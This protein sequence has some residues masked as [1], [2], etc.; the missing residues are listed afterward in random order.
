MFR[1]GNKQKIQAVIVVLAAALIAY[2]NST[3]PEARYTGAPGDLG[4]CVNCHDTFER[5]NVGP[6]N[7]EIGG[8]PVVYEP[9]RDYTLTVTVQQ[10]NRTRYGFQLTAID[11]DGA[12]AGTFAPLNGDTQLNV[13]TGANGRQYIQHTSQGTNPTTSGRRIWQ[14]RWT[15]PATD[16]G[17]VRFFVAGNAANGDGTNQNDYIYTNSAF[18]ESETTLV[19]LTLDSDPSGQELEP[20]SKYI[21]DWSATN[22]S[23]VDSYELRYSTDD[24]ATFPITNLIFSTTDPDITE[25]EWAVPDVASTSVRLRLQGATKAGALVGPILSGKFSINGTGTPTPRITSARV[26]GKKLFVSGENFQQGA[27]VEMN[28]V[29]QKTK[30]EE[31][32]SR[33]LKCKKAGKKINP[34]DTVDLVVRNPDGARSAVFPYTRPMG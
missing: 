26:D 31:D 14:V 5:P 11:K 30:N 6:G 2:A 16:I 33:E 20:G 18:S 13:L 32:F 15:A 23:N 28:G 12:R 3:G 1:L 21:I 25:Y 24:G 27:I 34:G 29:D 9:G 10:N 7:V 4:S 22:T 8:Q 17:T 19:T